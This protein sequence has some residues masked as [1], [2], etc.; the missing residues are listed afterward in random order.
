MLG[1]ETEQ[2]VEGILARI[3]I[4]FGHACTATP[5]LLNLFFYFFKTIYAQT[6]ASGDHLHFFVPVGVYSSFH[7]VIDLCAQD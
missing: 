1:V 4:Y 2:N 5:V 7:I 3:T 6:E